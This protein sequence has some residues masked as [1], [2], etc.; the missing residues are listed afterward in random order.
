ML[1]LFNMCQINRRTI[2]S[3]PDCERDAKD[4]ERDER[5]REREQEEA[6]E[7][8]RLDAIRA[9]EE[10]EELQRQARQ[11]PRCGTAVRRI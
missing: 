3:C 6:L 7:R 5:Q 10:Y 1:D 9:R 2:L 11:G 8:L 4:R